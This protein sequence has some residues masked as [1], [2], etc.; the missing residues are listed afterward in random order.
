M[1]GLDPII[2]CRRRLLSPF[3]QEIF[4]AAPE[5]DGPMKERP[6]FRGLLNRLVLWSEPRQC[7]GEPSG[8]RDHTFFL[9]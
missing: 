9:V 6:R 5:N 3:L 7:A 8:M 4:G 2:S 1:L